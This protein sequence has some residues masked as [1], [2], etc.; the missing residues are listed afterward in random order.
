MDVPARPPALAV[1]SALTAVAHAAAS[2]GANSKEVAQAV[3]DTAALLAFLEK[4]FC[5]AQDA[6]DRGCPQTVLGS[7]EATCDC[8]QLDLAPPYVLQSELGRWAESAILSNPELHGALETAEERCKFYEAKVDGL[9]TLVEAGQAVVQARVSDHV[10]CTGGDPP[11]AAELGE[12]KGEADSGGLLSSPVVDSLPHAASSDKDTLA[13]VTHGSKTV[14]GGGRTCTTT[15]SQRPSRR[16]GR[17]SGSKADVRVASPGAETCEKANVDRVTCAVAHVI[18]EAEASNKVD[19]ADSG[20]LHTG[21]VVA[22][23]VIERG[24]KADLAPVC[25]TSKEPALDAMSVLRGE[26]EEAVRALKELGA[27][28]Q[29]LAQVQEIKAK[30]G[31]ERAVKILSVCHD[32]F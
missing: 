32:V 4:P 18:D 19:A 5:G 28:P 13:A 15:A 14:D 23:S 1:A 17:K 9:A 30:V 2:L 29:V 10:A 16:E 7:L 26:W 24:S 21:P 11:V 20:C 25:E 22:S 3:E 12:A 6:A 8:F 27:T 31:V